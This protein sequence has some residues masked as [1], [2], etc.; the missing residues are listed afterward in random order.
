MAFQLVLFLNLSLI[1]SP[2]GWD[3]PGY[4]RFR[5]GMT[6]VKAGTDTHPWKSN[7]LQTV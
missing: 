6:D 1:G 5:P 3:F 4:S 7:A 2:P